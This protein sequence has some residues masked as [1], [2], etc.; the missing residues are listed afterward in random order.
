ST[1]KFLYLFADQVDGDY[2]V[3]SSIIEF[4]PIKP[5][6]MLTGQLLAVSVNTDI[7]IFRIG[8]AGILLVRVDSY[9]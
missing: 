6:S 5:A 7:S 1:D 3:I 8:A 2:E 9:P 4:S